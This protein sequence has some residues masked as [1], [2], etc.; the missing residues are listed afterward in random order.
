MSTP[1]SIGGREGPAARDAGRQRPGMLDPRLLRSSA[2]RERVS[3]AGRPT[4]PP[5]WRARLLH[6][7]PPGDP[8]V[9]GVRHDQNAGASRP[10]PHLVPAGSGSAPAAR[11]P[12]PV[13][14]W[15]VAAAST[16][17]EPLVLVAAAALLVAESGTLVGMALPGTTLLVA[18][19]LW[20]HLAP[21][22]LVP[23]IVAAAA[24]TVAG[25]TSWP[26]WPGPG[27]PGRRRWCCWGTASDQAC[28]PGSAGCRS[29]CSC[30]LWGRSPWCRGAAGL[31]GAAASHASLRTLSGRFPPEALRARWQSPCRAPRPGTLLP[32]RRLA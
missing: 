7:V 6:A 20:S 21:G 31:V 4:S 25:G 27:R 12:A 3:R 22:V 16:W 1:G 11:L 14:S 23:S 24:G 30:S 2:L 5:G 13:L 19:G 17:P 8:T 10:R 9:R 26:G 29:S 28:S 15:L 18:L 32:R